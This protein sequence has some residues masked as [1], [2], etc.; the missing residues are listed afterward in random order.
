MSTTTA[1]RPATVRAERRAR[2]LA[3]TG[4]LLRFNLRRDRIRLPAW[5]LAIT[6]VMVTSPG[7]Y[8]G[9][10]PT[11]ADR[12]NQAEVVGDN[13]AMKAMTGPGYGIDEGYSYGAMLANEYLGFIVIFVALMSVFIV[14]RHSRAEEETGRAE[15]IRSNVVGRHAQ[16]MA[17]LLT[18]VIANVALALF[19]GL[20]MGSS[21]VESIGMSG[22]MLFGAAM[23]SVG[24]V[25]AAIAAATAQ[26]TEHSRGASGIAGALIGVA[27]LLRAIGDTGDGTLSW[28]SPI[29]WAQ[30]TKVYVDDRWWPLGI[31]LTVTFALIAVAFAIESRRDM[32]AGLMAQRPGKAQATPS[33]GTPT[34]LAWR[35]QRSSAIWWAIALLLFGS[36]YGS[37][38]DIMEDYEDNEVIQDM[39]EAVGG[40]SIT[41]SWLS[42]IISIL[43]IVCSIYAVIAALRPQREETSGRAEPVLATAI[44]RRQFA[45]SHIA[46][47]LAG[48]TALLALTSAGLGATSAA[49]LDDPDFFWRVLGGGLAYAPALWVTVGFAVALYGL[50]PEWSTF[51][52]AVPVYSIFMAYLGGILQLP[53]WLV[54]ISPFMNISR[55]PAETMTWTAPIVLTALAAI[56]LTA[57][58]TAFNRRDLTMK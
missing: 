1:P 29:G 43:A 46:I 39:M 35:L 51:A 7:T 37:A 32:G 17:A 4:K 53:D 57:G 5:V 54:N 58:L 21:G 25:F 48:G 52:W 42:V 27:Y 40:A 11:S 15:L 12:I 34:G 36:A 13:P 10:Y 3:G 6:L 41:E 18:A 24:L 22:S 16:L 47:A 38:A 45:G 50:R 2:T 23:A 33:L 26:V 30:A 28:L 8:E 56:L 9:L 55:L 19:I 31:S 20:G 44:S 49:L 14:V